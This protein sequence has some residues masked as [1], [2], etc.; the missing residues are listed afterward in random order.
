LLVI[1]ID[2]FRAL[3][4]KHGHHVGDEAL[5]V[6]SNTLLENSRSNDIAARVGS[7]EFV[8][9]ATDSNEQSC[10]ILRDRIVL[11]AEKIFCDRGWDITLSHGSITE[12]GNKREVDAIIRS[13]NE[14][15]HSRKKEKQE[16][17]LTS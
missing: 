15:M 5:V 11:A 8:L 14:I 6:L 16:S 17:R 12:T 7:D 10:S 3:N 2:R 9:L 4:D 1:N 13:A